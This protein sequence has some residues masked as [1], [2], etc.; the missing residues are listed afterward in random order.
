VQTL[1]REDHGCVDT[2]FSCFVWSFLH[3]SAV[4][5]CFRTCGS[6][7]CAAEASRLWRVMATLLARA[8]THADLHVPWRAVS[9]TRVGW[10]LAWICVLAAHMQ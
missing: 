3:K 6:L 2:L 10:L 9:I 1:G 8:H 4:M 5:K 7:K